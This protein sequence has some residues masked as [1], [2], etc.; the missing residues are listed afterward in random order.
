M[1]FIIRMVWAPRLLQSCPSWVDLAKVAAGA[2]LPLWLLV[3]PDFP[4]RPTGSRTRHFL[5][6]FYDAVLWSSGCLVGGC[7]PDH[8]GREL[9]ARRH[10]AS[11]SQL[12]F[13]CFLGI[14]FCSYEDA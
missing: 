2:F 13:D 4:L 12:G 8:L 3:D 1:C 9:H 14:S 5:Q 11:W 7:R 6:W 10:E